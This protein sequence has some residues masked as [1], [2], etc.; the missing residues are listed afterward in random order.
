MNRIAPH[1]PRNAMG[2]LRHPNRATCMANST[3]AR[4]R[5][6]DFMDSEVPAVKAFI[7]LCSIE[8]SAFLFPAFILAA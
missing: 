5:M 7:E 3:V 6:S 8:V 1:D 4:M 2:A